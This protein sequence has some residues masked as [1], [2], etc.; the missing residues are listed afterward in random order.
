MHIPLL[1]GIQRKDILFGIYNVDKLIEIGGFYVSRFWATEENG[2]PVSKKGIDAFHSGVY[3]RNGHVSRLR[4]FI[5]T[6]YAKT[7]FISGVAYDAMMRFVDGKRY[8]GGYFNIRKEQNS[9]TTITGAS[10]IGPV[11]NIYDLVAPGRNMF[12]S[13][14]GTWGTLTIPTV[15]R[16][17]PPC[18]RSIGWNNS[19]QFTRATLYVYY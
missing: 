4:N 19:A 16:S 10:E 14:Q 5:N 11:C 7:S 13:E 3:D 15:T 2:V 17:S 1:I 18:M 6:R 12:T 9:E 8:S